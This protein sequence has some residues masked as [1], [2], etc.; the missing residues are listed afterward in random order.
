VSTLLLKLKNCRL[1]F[2]VAVD[3]QKSAASSGLPPLLTEKFDDEQKYGDDNGGYH[4]LSADFLPGK[5]KIV[6]GY[7]P[8]CSSGQRHHTD[9]GNINRKPE[10]L[11]HL[12][13][14]RQRQSRT[15][16]ICD[17]PATFSRPM[18]G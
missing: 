2:P 16:P 17:G 1:S 18:V 7:I 12:V 10:L 9:S 5:A 11:V 13:N 8:K 6:V 15:S 14:M 3:L 4:G